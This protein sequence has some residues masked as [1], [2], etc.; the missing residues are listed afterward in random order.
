MLV[1]SRL[2]ELKGEDP[3]QGLWNMYG[4]KVIRKLADLR[5]EWLDLEGEC[6]RLSR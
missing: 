2:P 4:I 1:K 6:I 5:D 3:M